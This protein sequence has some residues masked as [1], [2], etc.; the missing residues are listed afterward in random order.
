MKTMALVWSVI[1]ATMPTVAA[2]IATPGN[3]GDSGTTA[4]GGVCGCWRSAWIHYLY[5]ACLPG[6]R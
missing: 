3:S 4:V 1:M 5:S 6:V 2:M